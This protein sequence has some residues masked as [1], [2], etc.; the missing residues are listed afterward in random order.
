MAEPL[1]GPAMQGGIPLHTVW[2]QVLRP[3]PLVN[4]AG[5]AGFDPVGAY[6]TQAQAAMAARTIPGAL[7]AMTVIAHVNPMNMPGGL[8]NQ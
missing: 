5:V 1:V 4:S 7:I 3:K 8:L 2:W 6:E